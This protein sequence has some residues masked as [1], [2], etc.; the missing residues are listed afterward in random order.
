MGAKA[1]KLVTVSPNGQISIGK[2][3]AGR[4]IRV[5]EVN[6]NEIH[7]S[8]GMFVPDSQRPFFTDKASQ[9]LTEFNQFEAEKP[10]RATNTQTHFAHLKKKKARG[11]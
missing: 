4:Q 2:S 3:W 8:A 6:E 11:R 7:I 5:E 10:A 1:M 9:S